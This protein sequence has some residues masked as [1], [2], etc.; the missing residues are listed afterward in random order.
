MRA[1]VKGHRLE[2]VTTHRAKGGNS[3][4]VGCQCGWTK[5]LNRTTRKSAVE[6][7]RTHKHDVARLASSNAEE[8]YLLTVRDGYPVGEGVCRYC[9]IA[10][11]P[12]C[13]AYKCNIKD[14]EEAINDDITEGS[15]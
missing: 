12:V 6:A 8:L 15:E 1:P 3:Y 14:N 11:G 5:F 4:S 2:Y 13:G 7:H 9:G 10:P